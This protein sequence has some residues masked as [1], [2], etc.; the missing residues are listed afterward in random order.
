MTHAMPHAQ[1]CCDVPE[2]LT[3]Q[4]LLACRGNSGAP[5]SSLALQLRSTEMRVEWAGCI[6]G[7]PRIHMLCFIAILTKSGEIWRDYDE[8]WGSNAFCKCNFAQKSFLAKRFEKSGVLFG[9]TQI[10]FA[11]FHCDSDEI[12]RNLTNLEKSGTPPDWR[13]SGLVV[14]LND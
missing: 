12:W 13:Q 1:N 2:M 11:L 5:P 14:N 7:A 4:V 6:S 3:G 10:L 8:A 9:C